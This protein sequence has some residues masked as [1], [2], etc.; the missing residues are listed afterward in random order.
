M[1]NALKAWDTWKEV[2][3]S[4]RVVFSMLVSFL[5]LCCKVPGP[6]RGD[7]IRQI[8]DALRKKR[9]LLGMLVRRCLLVMHSYS[10]IVLA[11]SVICSVVSGGGEDLA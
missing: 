8:G 4:Q 6:K 2:Q 1:K 11:A 5:C 10:C 7:I 3:G 9:D